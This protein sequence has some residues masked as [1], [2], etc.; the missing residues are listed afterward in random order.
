MNQEKADMKNELF[1]KPHTNH[2]K[3]IK[4]VKSKRANSVIPE[5]NKMKQDSQE[6]NWNKSPFFIDHYQSKEQIRQK[7]L[8]ES[9][10]L[11][12]SERKR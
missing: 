12:K 3:G 2:L 10:K 11:R 5:T 9:R 1:V 6:L 4:V 8:Q 7:F